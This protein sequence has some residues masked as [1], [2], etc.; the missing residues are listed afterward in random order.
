MNKK[1]RTMLCGMIYILIFVFTSAP[2]F[3]GY[4]MEGGDAVMWLNRIREIRE[5]L[6]GGEAFWFPSFELITLHGTQTVAFD[7]GVWLLPVAGLQALGLGE[8]ISYCFFMGIIGIGT[9]AAVHWMM[10]SFSE[11]T[12]VMLY[13]V[14]FYMSC[15][16]RIYICFDKADMGQTLVWALTPLLIGGLTRARQGRNGIYWCVSALAYAGIWYADARWGVIIGGCAVL[17]LILWERWFGGL[18]LLAAGG[19]LSMPVVIYLVRYLI[20][21]G[22]QIWDLPTG[23]IMGNGYTPGLFMTSWA[24]RPDM[25]GLGMG[26][27]GAL[28]LL[29]WLYWSGSNGKM[30]KSIKGLL[31]ATGVLTLASLK[32]FPWDY[33]QRLGMPFL[34]FVSLL[35]TPGVFWGLANMLFAIPAAWTIGEVRKKQDDLWKWAIPAIL[36]IAALATALYL[37]NSLTYVRLPLGQQPVS[38]VAY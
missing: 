30:E 34:R 15:P 11:D 33:V 2:V 24:Y 23:S 32:Y 25:P 13:G 22:M 4:V 31:A 6:A 36:M 12:A 18:L 21:G 28:F 19:I 35:E 14:L 9:M 29:I 1:Q 3:C 27:A 26:L 37:C 7:S 16:F 20:K 38:E 8:Q 17:Y 5:N 10:K